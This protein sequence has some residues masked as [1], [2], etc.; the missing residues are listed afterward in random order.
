MSD[1]TPILEI[2]M[3]CQTDAERADWLL[4]A[5]KG[6]LFR[7]YCSIRRILAAAQFARGVDALDVEFAAINATRTT[8]GAL[9]AAIMSGVDTARSYL[10]GMA[11]TGLAGKAETG[12]VR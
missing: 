5:P 7:D 9:P 11:G 1:I 2:L 6:I 8:D 3:D 4:R 12:G 10:R